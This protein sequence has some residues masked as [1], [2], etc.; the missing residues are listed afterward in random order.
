MSALAVLCLA[1]L[2]ATAVT[3]QVAFSNLA[4][5]DRFETRAGILIGTSSRWANG[6]VI[7]PEVGGKLHLVEGGFA[8]V[9]PGIEMSMTLWSWTGFEPDSVLEQ[10]TSIVRADAGD[11]AVLA[12]DGWTVDLTAGTAYFL[13]A[14]QADRGSIWGL[15]Q[16]P[17]SIGEIRGEFRVRDGVFDIAGPL[18]LALRVTIADPVP[19]VP[20]PVPP[21][22][23]PLLL[24]LLAVQRVFSVSR[25][26]T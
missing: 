13:Q 25:R 7:V 6:P 12:F 26:R 2:P 22:G 11:A 17:A 14:G 1:A 4:A 3:T 5:D 21:G 8:A 23:A 15:A 19:I 20:A 10:V 9:D 24:A 18:P 16:V